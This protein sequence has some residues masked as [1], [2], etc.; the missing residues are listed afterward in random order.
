MVRVESGENMLRGNL[1]KDSGKFSHR[2]TAEQ[3]ACVHLLL[4]T[5]SSRMDIVWTWN[6][7][8]EKSPFYL[9]DFC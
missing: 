3:L 7:G 9:N 1:L 2:H 8:A 6:W 5:V 4:A